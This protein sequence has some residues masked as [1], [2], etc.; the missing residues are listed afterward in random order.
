MDLRTRLFGGTWDHD[1]DAMTAEEPVTGLI[2][3]FINMTTDVFS[4]FTTAPVV[5]FVG[6]AL[7]GVAIKFGKGLIPRKKN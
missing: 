2:S 3:S 6:L 7:L 5:Y 1:A 4:F